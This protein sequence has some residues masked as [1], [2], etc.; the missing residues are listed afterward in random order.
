MGMHID[1]KDFFKKKID[2][3]KDD[4]ARQNKELQKQQ[5]KN[6]TERKVPAR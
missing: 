1:E 6:N 3:M 4:I 2:R 5:K